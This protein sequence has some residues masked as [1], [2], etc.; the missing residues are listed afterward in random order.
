MR[1][2]QKMRQPS[3]ILF[4]F[5]NI[6]FYYLN[7]LFY[8]LNILF[9]QSNTNGVTQHSYIKKVTVLPDAL[10][11]QHII[12]CNKGRSPYNAFK[13]PW[14]GLK[15][16]TLYMYLQHRISLQKANLMYHQGFICSFNI[17]CTACGFITRKQSFLTPA[18]SLQKR[19]KRFNRTSLPRRSRIGTSN[20]VYA[21]FS[22][23]IR[24]IFNAK[25]VAYR[26]S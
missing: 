5:L 18:E 16:Y 17:L 14:S 25:E 10:K 24:T 4:Y 2:I 12:F 20:T 9:F 11:I 1:T 26:I 3:I 6:L 7:I 8:F 13:P 19:K 15:G 21:F 23:L 22:I